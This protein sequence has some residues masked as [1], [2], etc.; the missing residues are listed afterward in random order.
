MKDDTSLSRGLRMLLTVADHGTIRADVLATLL[1]MP[2]STVYRYLRTLTDFGFV[3]RNGGVYKLGMRLT[4]LQGSRIDSGMLVRVADSVLRSLVQA[5]EETA[6]IMTRVGLSALCLHQV[7]S[8]HKMRMAFERGEI[9]PLY[10]GASSKVLLAYAPEEVVE[11]VIA[12]HLA[13]LTSN[14]PDAV[15]LR[16]DLEDIR[17]T[18]LAVSQGELIVGASAV[19]VPVFCGSEFVASLAVAGPDARCNAP[20]RAKVKKVLPE[21]GKS[22]RQKLEANVIRRPGGSGA[23]T[24]HKPGTSSEGRL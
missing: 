23:R 14:T 9:Q 5:T 1:G 18:G 6:L 12:D 21:A 10:A 11:V 8:F 2:L 7:E 4:I 13:P 24:P 20:W 16:K 3:E 17:R 19:A 22:L 15:H